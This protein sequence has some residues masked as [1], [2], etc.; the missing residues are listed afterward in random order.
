MKLHKIFAATVLAVAASAS[1]AVDFTSSLD[2]SSGNAS[3]GRDNA[4]GTFHDVYFFTLTGSQY[5][6]AAT[7]SS[8]ASG[9]QDLDFSSL[10][11]RTSTAALVATFASN[12]GTGANELYSLSSTL[13]APGHYRL[14]VRGINS[15]SQ[16]SYTGNLSVTAV[17]EPE[18]YALMLAG[19]GAVGFMVR[20][21]KMI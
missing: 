4:V 11:I 9:L 7:A 21:R 8:A 17:P 13:L 1:F 18:T 6:L 15:D 5:L 19:L 12:L 2:L 3:F 14:V 10:Q 16:A 20:R